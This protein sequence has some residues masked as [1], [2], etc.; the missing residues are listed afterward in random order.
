MTPA[1]IVALINSQIVSNGM[2]GITG[3]ILNAILV[4]IC[5]LFVSNAPPYRIVSASIN[6]ALTASDFR[7]GLLRTLN[8]AQTQVQ[9]ISITPGNEV[10]I[11]D[12]SGN[13][14]AYP[15]TVLPPAGMSFAGGRASYVMSED[16][17]T[18]RFAFYGQNVW[19]V[20][21]A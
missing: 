9:L 7:I 19:G 10:V 14:N 6:F 12:L 15:V 2:S 11:Q 3:P 13:F 18:A 5:N 8:L 17:Q 4:A 1:Q 21:P 16:N 20:E